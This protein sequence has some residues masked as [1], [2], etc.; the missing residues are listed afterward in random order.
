M[1]VKQAPGQM[2]HRETEHQIIKTACAE[3]QRLREL[4]EKIV[5]SELQKRLLRSQP[6]CSEYVDKLM[7]FA[8]KFLAGHPAMVAD[9]DVFVKVCNYRQKVC[10]GKF[11]HLLTSANICGENG[12]WHRKS[13]EEQDDEWLAL[14]PF[15][16][17]SKNAG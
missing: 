4:D 13:K 14:Y 11:F 12:A 1:E 7:K 3:I 9:V 17:P 16:F 10:H 8:E 5:Q 6:P 15:P 2:Q